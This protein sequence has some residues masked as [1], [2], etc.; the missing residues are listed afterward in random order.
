MCPRSDFEA[1]RRGSSI[2]LNFLVGPHWNTISTTSNLVVLISRH[3]TTTINTAIFAI[4]LSFICTALNVSTHS[5]ETAEKEKDATQRGHSAK[6]NIS[7]IVK[8]KR[9]M[10]NKIQRKNSNLSWR[11]KQKTKA[12]CKT[13]CEKLRD[14]STVDRTPYRLSWR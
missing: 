10:V 12:F 2:G 1:N 14:E 5:L 9:R 3:C 11:V 7:Y 4:S 13:V 6:P 8:T